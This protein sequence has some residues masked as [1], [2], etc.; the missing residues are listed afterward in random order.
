M[1]WKNQFVDAGFP[2]D[3]ATI[4]ALRSDLARV[5]R[6]YMERQQSQTAAA[7]KLGISQGM[8]SNIMGGRIDRISIERLVKLMVL[9]EISGT[10]QWSGDPDCARAVTGNWIDATADTGGAANEGVAT[11]D[12]DDQMAEWFSEGAPTLAATST[13]N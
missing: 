11:E 7:K 13:H 5:L 6:Q 4:W 2:A 8:V 10:A 1:R 12:W 9:A 3:E